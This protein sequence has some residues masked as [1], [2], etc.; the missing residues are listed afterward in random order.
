[1]RKE[2]GIRDFVR[3]TCGQSKWSETDSENITQ[4]VKKKT[5]RLRKEIHTIGL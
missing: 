1:M 4:G 2:T 5:I 3:Q